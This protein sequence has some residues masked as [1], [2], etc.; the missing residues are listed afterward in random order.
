MASFNENSAGLWAEQGASA[1]LDYSLDYSDLCVNGDVIASSNWTCSDPAIVITN[2]SFQG[3]FASAWFS[4]GVV[5]VW[6][7]LVN[8]IVTQA[9]RADSRTVLLFISESTA[10]ESPL[11]TALFPNKFTAINKLRRD[12]LM[13]LA[14][15]LL[16]EITVHDDYLWDKLVAAESQISHTLRCKFE[17]TRFFPSQPTPEQIAALGSMP[18]DIDPA[19]DYSPDNYLGDKWGFIQTRQKPVQSVVSMKFLYPTPN[20]VIVEVPLDWIRMDG[21][22]GQIQILPT[23]TSYP[24]MMGGMFMSQLSGGRSLPFTISLEY[25]AGLKD[26]AKTYPELVDAVMKMA[27]VK[28]VEDS[29]MPQ[30]GSISAD[31]LSQS[32]SVDVSKY[33]DSVETIINGPSGSNGGLMSKIN[34][35]RMVVM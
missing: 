31:G 35:I 34:G 23:G 22:A 6:Y 11:G 26:A 1:N 30:S 3:A 5:G 20:N 2:K 33:E 27:A 7:K 17:P 13:L 19:Y 15:S 14:N 12:R 18:W 4:G 9:G 21:R 28:I 24:T 16:P 32:M 10:Q 25:V 29:F 8:S